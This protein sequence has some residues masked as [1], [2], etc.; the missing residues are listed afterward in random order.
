LNALVHQRRTD[1]SAAER[2]LEEMR[3]RRSDI[4]LEHEKTVQRAGR[5]QDQINSL[6]ERKTSLANERAR[7][8][9]DLARNMADSKAR[10]DQL[11][12]IDHEKQL[13]E[14]QVAHAGIAVADCAERRS[15]EER[16]IELLRQQQFESVGREAQ[17]RN[18]VLSRKEIIARISAQVDRLGREE[19]EA[20]QHAADLEQQLSGVRDEYAGQQAGFG[21]LK[22]RLAEAEEAFV[23]NKLDHANALKAAAEAKNDE[24]SIRHR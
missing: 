3:E 15:A 17:L 2:V 11:S 14:E 7:A 13:A 8:E 21:L 6:E 19:A 18:E 5:L 23:K 24:D 4:E 20:R 1:V 22:H 16:A 10:A 12:R 9:A